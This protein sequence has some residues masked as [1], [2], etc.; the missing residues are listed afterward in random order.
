M[1]ADMDCNCPSITC[2]C[3]TFSVHLI[4]V[5]TNSEIVSPSLVYTSTFH[6]SSLS[7]RLLVSIFKESRNLSRKQVHCDHPAS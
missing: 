2:C 3:S 5:D 6:G 1:G 4:L 7:M